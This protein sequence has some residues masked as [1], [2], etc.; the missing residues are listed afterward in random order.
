MILMEM[1]NDTFLEPAIDSLQPVSFLRVYA[2]EGRLI[3][4][5]GI[6]GGEEER[7]RE[8]ERVI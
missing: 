1:S 3:E 5:D 7:G 4:A 6:L 2:N 8:S